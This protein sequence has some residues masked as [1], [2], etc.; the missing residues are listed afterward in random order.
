MEDATSTQMLSMGSGVGGSAGILSIAVWAPLLAAFAGNCCLVNQRLQSVHSL[1][2]P[3]PCLEQHQQQLADSD[4]PSSGE[5]I[6]G[7]RLH[8]LSGKS[9]PLLF[10]ENLLC[11][12]LCPLSPVLSLGTADGSL[13][14]SSWHPPCR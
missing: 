1:S 11:V 4:V 12:S 13:A 8:N 9:K 14:L 5:Y 3:A 7:Q 10:R 6:P 2:A